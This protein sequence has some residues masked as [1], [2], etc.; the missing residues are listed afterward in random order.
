M[1]TKRSKAAGKP[2]QLRRRDDQAITSNQHIS[3]P[4]Q[5]LFLDK[6][7]L[8]ESDTFGNAYKSAKAAG[9]SENYA[10]QILSPAVGNAWI[11]DNSRFQN[12]SYEHL[13][14]I[15]DDIATSKYNPHIRL[16]AI[17]LSA[18]LKGLMIERKQVESKVITVSLGAI[19]RKDNTTTNGSA[20]PKE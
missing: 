6:Y 15:V 13:T 14:A 17:E 12:L 2:S 1:A 20:K 7:L 9:Y 3:D 10:R 5:D 4:K 16:K 11:K 19:I 8:P 18:R